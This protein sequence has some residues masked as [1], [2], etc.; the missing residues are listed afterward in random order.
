MSLCFFLFFL[1]L[2]NLQNWWEDSTKNRFLEKANCI[3]WQYGNYTAEAV[4][5]TLNGVNTQVQNIHALKEADLKKKKKN[6][7][8][9]CKNIYDLNSKVQLQFDFS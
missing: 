5:K 3:V 6:L 8:I 2:G 4:N 1:F 7:F 9:F